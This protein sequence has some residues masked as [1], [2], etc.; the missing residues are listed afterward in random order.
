MLTMTNYNINGT[1]N[2]EGIG[3]IAYFNANYSSNNSSYNMNISNRK[4]YEANKQTVDADFE[5]FKQKADDYA[6]AITPTAVI[7]NDI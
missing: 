1:S 6:K 2:L 3:D 7:D 5:E 4:E